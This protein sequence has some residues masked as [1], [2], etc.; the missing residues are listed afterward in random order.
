MRPTDLDHSLAGRLARLAAGLSIAP[1]GPALPRGPMVGAVLAL[2][3]AMCISPQLLGLLGLPYDT[4]TGSPLLKLHPATWLTAAALAAALAARGNPLRELAQALAHQPATAA[5]LASVLLMIAWS[6]ARFGASGAA[7]FIDT[8]LVPGLMV[9]LLAQLPLAVQQR[10]FSL[11]CA[12]LMGNAL[13]GIGEQLLENR[14]IP[15]TVGGVPLV[16]DLFRATALLGHPLSNA[17][18][19]GFGLFALYGLRDRAMRLACCLVAVVALLSFGGRTALAASLLLLAPLALLDLA[20]HVRRQGLAYRELAGGLALLIL[21]L[22]LVVAAV[23]SGSVGERIMG[24]LNWDSSAQVRER[25]L[26]VLG[27]MDWRQ[28]L[29]GMSPE[30]IVRLAARAG[31][32][33]PDAAIESFWILIGMQVGLPLMALFAACLGLFLCRLARQAGLAVGLGLV[34]FVAVV[35]TSVSLA[36]KTEI[37][38]VVAALAQLAGTW[39]WTGLWQDA[40]ARLVAECE[41][42]AVPGT[43]AATA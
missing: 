25:M 14:L 27:L 19:T 11:A 4:P 34:G 26:H 31:I 39:R 38:V 41:D 6:V 16:E 24:S 20:R 36:S 2:L 7:F 28:V 3:A 42:G 17:A 10:L 33:F 40:G 32:V 9:L 37:L 43:V 22:G 12:V 13:L 1:F 8:L 29:L 15:L 30:E 21:V 5:Y 18:V 23:A 35:S